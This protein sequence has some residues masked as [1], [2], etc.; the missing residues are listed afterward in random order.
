MESK[1]RKKGT[2][3]PVEWTWSPNRHNDVDDDDGDATNHFYCYDYFRFRPPLFFYPCAHSSI[4]CGCP[5][6]FL[7]LCGDCG[8]WI[9][10]SLTVMQAMDKKTM[11]TKTKSQYFRRLSHKVFRFCVYHFIYLVQ[12]FHLDNKIQVLYY[13]SPTLCWQCIRLYCIVAG[14]FFIIFCCFSGR[15]QFYSLL[16]FELCPEK[17]RKIDR[18][19][20]RKKRWNP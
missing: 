14:V 7:S 2:E 5:Q 16:C 13:L 3:N 6:K 18:E 9:F 17:N 8:G 19:R 12:C 11:S 15:H 1:N 20:E 10:F 4:V